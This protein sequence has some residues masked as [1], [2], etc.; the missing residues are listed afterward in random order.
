M[1][2][3]QNDDMQHLYVHLSLKC[4]GCGADEYFLD[5]WEGVP[6]GEHGAVAFSVRASRL[7]KELGWVPKPDAD[8]PRF[9][10]PAC[11]PCIDLH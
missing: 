6:A 4:A 8:E 2:A 1:A 10:C 9:H 5:C 3:A 7:A 11:H